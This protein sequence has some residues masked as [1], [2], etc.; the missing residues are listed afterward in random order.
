[1]P[2]DQERDIGLV[3]ITGAGASC[4]FG[5]NQTQLPMMREWSDTLVTRLRQKGPGFLEATG[6]EPDLDAEEFEKR[7]GEFLQS[8]EAFKS[9]GRLL[10]P[11]RAMDPKRSPFPNGQ[12]WHTWHLNAESKLDEIVTVIYA[13]LYELFAQPAID[14]VLAQEAYAALVRVFGI[15]RDSRWVYATTNYDVVG[16]NALYELGLK[17]DFGEDA[18]VPGRSERPLRV[19]GLLD[20]L[21]RFVP[22]L[23]LHGRVGWFRREG[24]PYSAEIGTFDNAYG[25]PIVMLPDLE[26]VYEVDA[27]IDPIWR[28]FREALQRAQRVFVLGHSLHDKALIRALT[29]NVQ[30]KQRI[31]VTFLPSHEEPR[32]AADADAVSVR[33]RVEKELTGAATIPMRFEG[34]GR[35]ET[36]DIWTTAVESWLQEV[37]RF[38]SSTGNPP[39]E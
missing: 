39:S 3:L 36:R 24:A 16:E 22:V 29:D 13:S 38:V 35:L 37:N 17:P 18:Y 14:P 11:V 32:Q 23:H 2:A 27:V 28:Q 25:T 26:K 10:D 15:D 31:A 12:E 21:P 30:P 6:L 8:S 20:G 5:V 33:D 1:M 9:I 7:L 19:N 4:A 34:G